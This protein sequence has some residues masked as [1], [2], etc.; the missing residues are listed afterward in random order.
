MLFNLTKEPLE[1]AQ[2]LY[3]Q[4]R[5]WGIELQRTA[6]VQRLLRNVSNPH[7]LKS[8]FQGQNLSLQP[9]I[10]FVL[11]NQHCP[12]Y[13]PTS[14]FNQM[15]LFLLPFCW[16]SYSHICCH[17]PLFYSVT[18]RIWAASPD[19]ALC[20]CTSLWDHDDWQEREIAGWAVQFTS[21]LQ[22]VSFVAG[23]ILSYPCSKLCLWVKG[24][25]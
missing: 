14:H 23:P 11:L 5:N 1:A 3:H 12:F 2:E 22:H 25:F 20:K 16:F 18:K 19:F 6:N 21:C 4:L 9:K 8:H 15:I 7:D 10:W 13:T 17:S 24:V